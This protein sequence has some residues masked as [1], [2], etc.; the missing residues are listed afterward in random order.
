MSTVSMNTWWVGVDVAKATL[1][2]AVMAERETVAVLVGEFANDDSG[3]VAL[4][5]AVVQQRETLGAPL[6]SPWSPS[7]YQGLPLAFRPP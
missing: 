3:F 4:A 7:R 2:V 1:A 5:D 6:G